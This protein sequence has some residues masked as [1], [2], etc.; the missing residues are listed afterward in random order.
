MFVGHSKAGKSRALRRLGTALRKLGY[1]VVLISFNDETSY[2]P[3]EA[4]SALQSVLA[5]IAYAIAKP[6]VT[7]GL[8]LHDDTMEQTTLR[9]TTTEDA[10]L[11]WLQLQGENCI[12]LIDELNN[13]IDS[14]RLKYRPPQH[15][16]DEVVRFLSDVFVKR[17]RGYYAFTTHRSNTRRIVEMVEGYNGHREIALPA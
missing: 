3:N 14:P 12:L 11:D 15:E 17:P 2:Y 4:S 5:R 9:F 13:C 7:N 1:N 10:V 6:D 8:P 16:I